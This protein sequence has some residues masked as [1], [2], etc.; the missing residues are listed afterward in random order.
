MCQR[1]CKPGSVHRRVAARMG[2]H[3]SRGRSY[4]APPATNPGD[5]P[6]QAHLP[7][8]FGLAPGGVY[9]AA[10]VAGAR[11][12]LLPH[13]FALTRPKTGRMLSVALSLTPLAA[14]PPGVTRHRC[15]VEPGLSSRE[16][17]RDAAARPSG[18]ARYGLLRARKQ[19]GQ[20]L[21]PAFAVDDAVDQVGA[22]AALEG[23]HRLLRRRSRHSR[24]ARARA[25]S[26][27]RSRTGR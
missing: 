17:V 11:G 23:D 15:S 10:A 8:L 9:R 26:R 27:R 6:E 20:Q 18:G 16:Q 12:A 25:G 22:E 24:T 21:G 4:P 19:Q 2:D 14:R 1:T 7:P 3:S 13:P 5:E